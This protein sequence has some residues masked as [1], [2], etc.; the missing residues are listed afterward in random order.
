[1]LL[2]EEQAEGTDQETERKKLI[3][4]AGGSLQAKLSIEIRCYLFKKTFFFNDLLLMVKTI[5]MN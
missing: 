3:Q 2:M 1:M 4:V 5:C